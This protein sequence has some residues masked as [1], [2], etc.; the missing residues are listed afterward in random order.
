MQRVDPLGRHREGAQKP[1]GRVEGTPGQADMG[2][3]QNGSLFF[4]EGSR[5]P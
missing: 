5:A 3:W 4:A 1:Q 2:L